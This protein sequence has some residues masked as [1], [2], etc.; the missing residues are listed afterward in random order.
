MATPFIMST[1]LNIALSFRSEA[2]TLYLL[3]RQEVDPMVCD[4]RHVRALLAACSNA[5]ISTLRALLAAATARSG[6]SAKE[7]L[8]ERD[9]VPIGFCWPRF[10]FTLNPLSLVDRRVQELMA[11]LRDEVGVDL[12]ADYDVEWFEDDGVGG[13][14]PIPNRPTRMNALLVACMEGA[15]PVVKWLVEVAGEGK[16]LESW[17]ASHSSISAIGSA[18]TPLHAA[19]LIKREGVPEENALAVVKYLVEEAG[20]SPDPQFAEA[21]GMERVTSYLR[22]RMRVA[23]RAGG[24]RGGR[25]GAEAA[26]TAD[27]AATA[28]ESEAAQREREEAAAAR[29]EALLLAELAAEEAA[30]AAAGGG[31]GNGKKKKKKGK[32]TGAGGGGGTGQDVAEEEKEAGAAAATAAAAALGALTL[33]D[34]AAAA[35]AAEQEQQDEQDEQAWLLETAPRDFTCPISPVL[36][37]E[38]RVASD[39]FTCTC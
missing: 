9:G 8:E 19:C 30:G 7:L 23:Q 20:A 4:D 27:T 38:P 2:A 15:L 6:R 1:P 25:G 18:I 12:L 17:G 32:R 35:A 14:R 37:T 10:F 36:L 5:S 28:T 29:A 21:Y 3:G 39:G 16:P 26:A 11:F 34:D 22:L 13:R 33:E 24:R 31:G